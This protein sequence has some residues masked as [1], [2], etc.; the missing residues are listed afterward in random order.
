MRETGCAGVVVGRGCLGR[1]W[2]F[3]DLADV[4]AGREPDDPPGFGEVASIMLDHAERLAGWMG[5]RLGV[6]NFRK[7]ATWYTKGFPGSTRLRDALIRIESLDE[8]RAILAGIDAS[9]PFPAHA[10]RLPRGK[11]GGTQ[12]VAL[13]DGYLDDLADATPPAAELAVAEAVSGG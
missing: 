11:R 13:P 1:P 3:R 8:L 5:E 4:F 7:H 2:L 6:R 9:V 10:M 12:R